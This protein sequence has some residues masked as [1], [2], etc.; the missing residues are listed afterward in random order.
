MTIE[1][2]SMPPLYPLLLGYV[3]LCWVTMWWCH[4]HLE[5]MW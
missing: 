5:A 4:M 3:F 2:W 1:L